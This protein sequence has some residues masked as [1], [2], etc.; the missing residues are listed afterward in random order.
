[1]QVLRLSQLGILAKQG[2]FE[3]PLGELLKEELIFFEELCDVD[4]FLEPE[5]SRVL[6]LVVVLL[7]VDALG[8]DD[9]SALVV[10]LDPVIDVPELLA[11]F[12]EGDEAVVQLQGQL[13]L[14]Q[15]CNRLLPLQHVWQH[16]GRTV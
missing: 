4:Y 15:F 10:P 9:F 2:G 5:H 11:E 12:L 14:Q 8:E 1:M 3:G 6:A 16:R 7:E 13:L